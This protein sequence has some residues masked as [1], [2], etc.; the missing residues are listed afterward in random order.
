MLTKSNNDLQK[1]FKVL[2]E[3]GNVNIIYKELLTASKVLKKIYKSN[4]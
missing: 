1:T 3:M 4:L 2:Q